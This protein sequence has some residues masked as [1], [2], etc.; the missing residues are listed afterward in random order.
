MVT[1][2]ITNYGGVYKLSPPR[3]EHADSLGLIRDLSQL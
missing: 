1:S 2:F 3:V